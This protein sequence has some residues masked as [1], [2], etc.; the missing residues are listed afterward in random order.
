[1]TLLRALSFSLFD[2]LK[3]ARGIGPRIAGITTER[4]CNKICG[5]VPLPRLRSILETHPLLL[6]LRRSLGGGI[7]QEKIIEVRL[8]GFS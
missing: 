4:R 8:R 1:M 7:Q 6:I 2:K 5:A 3:G